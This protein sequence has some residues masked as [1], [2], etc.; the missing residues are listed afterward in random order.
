M[1]LHSHAFVE[2][3]A[4]SPARLRTAMPEACCYADGSTTHFKAFGAS[5]VMGNLRMTAGARAYIKGSATSELVALA[6]GLRL[7]QTQML[8]ET[9]EPYYDLCLDSQIAV[10]YVN[11]GAVRAPEG[12]KLLP[13]IKLCLAL[14]AQVRR[15]A[16]VRVLKISRHLNREADKA[17]KDSRKQVMS[18]HSGV[19]HHGFEGY[20]ELLV[21]VKEVEQA[22][23]RLD[24]S[25]THQVESGL[26]P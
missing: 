22:T 6:L 11:G 25:D 8:K 13:L 23:I 15:R 7:I 14:L 19:S 9:P 18:S 26:S 21:A 2:W 24:G 20:P 5:A 17:A 4:E 12:T 3:L 10:D 1:L 16:N